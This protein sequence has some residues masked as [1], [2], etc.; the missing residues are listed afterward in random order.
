MADSE[1]VETRAL[2]TWI[3]RVF[4][5]PEANQGEERE[6]LSTTRAV[7]GFSLFTTVFYLVY[8]VSTD[9]TAFRPAIATNVGFATAYSVGFLLVHL[10]IRLAAA[11]LALSSAVTHIL[12]STW[13]LGSPAGLHVLLLVMGQVVFMVFTDAQRVYRWLFFGLAA[14]VFAYCQFALEPAYSLLDVPDGTARYLFSYNAAGTGLLLTLLAAVAHSRGRVAA[15]EANNAASRARF[16]ANTDPLTGLANRRPVADE[17]DRVSASGDYC[18]VVAD[19]DNFKELNDLHG[20]LCGDQVLAA[21]GRTLHDHVREFDTV[22]RWGGEEFIFV[23]PG[24]SVDDAVRFAERLRAA[25]AAC[26]VECGGHEHS[27]TASFGVAD[28]VDDGMSHRVVRRAD[29]AMY[30]AKQA[31]RNCV[32]ARPLSS[33][34]LEP[35]TSEMPTVGRDRRRPKA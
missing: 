22:G 30:E 5:G 25:V 10:G 35:P 23:L 18:V 4:D 3:T 17:L 34:V 1:R 29:D 19:L 8:Y 6:A 20:H 7:L 33:V 21:V 31:G 14:A 16:L 24:T 15:A 11:V 2:H 12:I 13:F 28:G 26:V 27:V 32:R 9:A